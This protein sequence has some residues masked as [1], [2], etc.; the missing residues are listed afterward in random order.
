LEGDEKSLDIEEYAKAVLEAKGLPINSRSSLIVG[1][2]LEECFE[3]EYHALALDVVGTITEPE[4]IQMTP[5]L[6]KTISEIVLKGVYVIFV[7]GSG[8]TT[9]KSIFDQLL[10]S[11]RGHE[12]FFRRL[13]AISGNGCLLTTIDPQGKLIEKRI[14]KPLREFLGESSYD[15][16]IRKLGE[17]FKSEFIID[18][19]A[20]SVRLISKQENLPEEITIEIESWFKLDCQDL[21]EK[22]LNIISGQWGAKKTFEISEADKDHSLC[23]FYTEYDFIDVPILRIG[24]QGQE[25]ANDFFFLD[26]QDGF[27]VGTFSKRMNRC[28]PVYNSDEKRLLQGVEGAEYLL[29][30]LNWSSSLR[31]PSFQV[32]DLEPVY[33]DTAEQLL[34]DAQTIFQEF[35]QSWSGMAKDKLPPQDIEKCAQSGF[36]T[37]YDHRSGAIR[38]SDAEWAKLGASRMKSYFDERDDPESTDGSLR[39][40]RSMYSDTGRLLRGPRYYLGLID[41]SINEKSKILMDEHDRLVEITINDVTKGDVQLSFKDWKL[42]LGILDNLRNSSRILYSMLFQAAS[43]TTASQTYW[44]RILR[45][46]EDYT[47]ASLGLYYSKLM[48]DTEAFKRSMTDLRRSARALSELRNI[49]ELLCDFLSCNK[50]DT[51]KIVRK[52]REVDHPGQIYSCMWS[53][54]K[55][56]RELTEK[57]HNICALGIMYGGI[58]LPFVFRQIHC[59]ESHAPIKIAHIAGISLYGRGRGSLLMERFSE[60][61]LESAIPNADWIEEIMNPGDIVIPL[62]DN[63]M[64]GRTMELVRD[65]LRAYRVEVPFCICVR[66]PPPGRIYHMVMKRHGGIDPDSLGREVKGLVA[67]SPY[68]RIFSSG[69]DYKDTLGIFDRSRDRIIQYL[70]KDGFTISED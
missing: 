52:W 29:R 11:I 22:G 13:Y 17:R 12:S 9:V 66:F 36:A 35:A 57:G 37:L 61:V 33:H 56:V 32:R 14:V 53:V 58:E 38:F 4:S 40:L 28:F 47:S 55:D 60:D 2:I 45:S 64:S 20:C 15:E 7:T 23:W 19:K 69:G 70:K 62:D 59:P 31:I 30:H 41:L 54:R 6:L 46:F 39:L 51:G 50:I 8:R 63:I 25:G 48:T 43:L 18:Q 26:S 67:K 34:V 68:S 1:G 27:S 5:E 24:D 16:L 10:P 3:T 49:T 42:E 21:Y 44:K 65:R